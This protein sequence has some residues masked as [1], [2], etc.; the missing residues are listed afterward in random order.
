MSLSIRFV[1]V[2]AN[3]AVNAAANAAVNVAVYSLVNLYFK[4][5]TEVK[6]NLL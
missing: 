3:A 5:K 6:K 4:V 1:N 2:A